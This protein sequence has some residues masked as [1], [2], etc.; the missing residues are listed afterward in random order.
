MPQDKFEIDYAYTVKFKSAEMAYKIQIEELF[1][2]LDH[3]EEPTADLAKTGTAGD[4]HV[5]GRERKDGHDS[6]SNRKRPKKHR[7]RH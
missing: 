4:T 6:G 7:K 1:Y 5:S 3:P 2:R